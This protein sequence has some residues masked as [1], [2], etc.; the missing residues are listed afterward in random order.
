MFVVHY[1][2]RHYTFALIGVFLL[3]QLHLVLLYL[4]AYLFPV[5]LPRQPLR[6]AQVRFRIK[7][8]IDPIVFVI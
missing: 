6:R 5:I 3:T 2:Q 7:Y 1:L 8:F 4:F